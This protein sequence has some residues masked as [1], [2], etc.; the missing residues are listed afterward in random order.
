MN[1]ARNTGTGP[2]PVIPVRTSSQTEMA[3]ENACGAVL[4]TPVFDS[5]SH[6]RKIS[7]GHSARFNPTEIKPTVPKHEQALHQL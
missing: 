7:R 3:V 2:P 1:S 4:G 5:V 6:A